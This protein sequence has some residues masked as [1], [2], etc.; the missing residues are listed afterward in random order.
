MTVSL[1]TALWAKLK[2]P[3]IPLWLNDGPKHDDKANI[4]DQFDY[5]LCT[6]GGHPGPKDEELCSLLL[7]ALDA[8]GGCMRDA[9]WAVRDNNTERAELILLR[10]IAKLQGKEIQIVS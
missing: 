2:L 8:C 1:L 9:A 10:A 7:W 6:S 5:Y 3:T 4:V